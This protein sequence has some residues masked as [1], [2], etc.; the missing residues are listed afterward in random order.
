MRKLVR[1]AIA[2][3]R[4]NGGTDVRVSEGGNHTF[5][6]FEV[7]ERRERVI[8]HRGG[9]VRSRQASSLRSMIRRCVNG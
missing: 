2:L 7:G 5:V 9:K 8:L 3:I 6:E 1:E 4:D